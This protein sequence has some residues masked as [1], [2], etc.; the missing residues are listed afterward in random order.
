M[1]D[2]PQEQPVQ[3]TI[4]R[5]IGKVK[6]APSLFEN[7][8]V[9]DIIGGFVI[10]LFKGSVL[11]IV[12]RLLYGDQ[13]APG[14]G[15]NLSSG[16]VTYQKHFDQSLK[17]P[18]VAQPNRFQQYQ[19]VRSQFPQLED[20]AFRNEHEASL[21]VNAIYERIEQYSYATV[22]DLYEIV[23]LK[24]PDYTY[25]QFGWNMIQLSRYELKTLP[26][27]GVLLVMPR[28]FPLSV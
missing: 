13:G 23:G 7:P 8:I 12:E 14:P 21:V 2:T 22:A 17:F 4:V 26:S 11:S 10:P 1:T 6:R 24:V 25:V 16:R 5:P 15:T 3:K 18:A 9:Q 19:Q 28:P 20:L 27:G